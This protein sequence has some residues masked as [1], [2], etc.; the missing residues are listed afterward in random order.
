MNKLIEKKISQFFTPDFIAKFMVE[1]S[2]KFLKHRSKIDDLNTLKVLEPSAG[3]GIFLKYL[4][5]MGLQNVTACEIDSSLETYLKKEY[6]IVDLRIKNFL[7]S[8]RK[9]EYDLV[10]GNPPYLGQ[11]YNSELFKALRKKFELCEEFFVGNMDLFYFFIHMGIEKL[12]P[13]GILSFITTNYWIF[14]SQKTGIKYLKPYIKDNCNLLQYI[15]LSTLKI[16]KE[17]QGQHNCI[18]LL[19]KKIKHDQSYPRIEIIDFKKAKENESNNNSLDKAFRSL[20]EGV[21]NSFYNRY[22]SAL[23]NKDLKR[24][25]N[26]NILYPIEVKKMVD[27]IEARCIENGKVMYIKDYFII[28]N[29][30]IFIKDDIFILKD[31]ESLKIKKD[32]FYVKINEKFVY[33][34]EAERK[35]LKKVYKSRVIR[36]FGYDKG[37]YI[38]L[39]LYFNRNEFLTKDGSIDYQLIEKKYPVLSGYLKQY[40]DNLRSIL[41]NAKENPKDIYFPRRGAY[42]WKSDKNGYLCDLER[43]YEQRDKIFF[44]YISKENTFGYTSEPYYA[45]SDT[46]FFWPLES[47]SNINY[48]FIVAYLNSELVRFLFKAKN[49]KIKRSK[50][51]LE[52]SIPIP[53]LRL[54]SS[55]KKTIIKLVIIFA[56]S[57]TIMGSI[58]DRTTFLKS[59]K[60][61]ISQNLQSVHLLSKVYDIED[62]LNSTQNNHILS[63]K[64]LIDE[65]LYMFFN[66]ERK[67]IKKLMSNYYIN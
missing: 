34:P 51:K 43:W 37:K 46:Y 14:K 30:L 25:G 32:D 29:G 66:I 65:L 4:I 2:I 50:T 23:S 56:K 9:E 24:H 67:M 8:P 63:I 22:T 27:K 42:V 38:G 35:I 58:E 31:G 7:G 55:L 62:I 48:F 47:S 61:E 26:W 5:D 16:F 44:S 57:L 40:E 41:I 54:E 18:F 60:K 28:R 12:K 39:G 11:N 45:T 13:G 49:I 19:Q 59:K 33:L 3:K 1:N 15:D 21:S 52:N 64:N 36:K 20:I 17:A 10:I 6:P 53:S